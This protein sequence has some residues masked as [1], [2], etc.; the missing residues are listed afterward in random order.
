M[1]FIILTFCFCINY[2]IFTE[3]IHLKCLER[4]T[5]SELFA[6]LKFNLNK[7]VIFTDTFEYDNYEKNIL[8]DFSDAKLKTIH[9]I[10]NDYNKNLYH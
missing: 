7:L 10:L 2:N 4:P 6:V 8:T 9:V 1:I 5:K 3:G